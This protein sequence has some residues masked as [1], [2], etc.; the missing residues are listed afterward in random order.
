M[1]KPLRALLL[2]AGFG[3][4]LKP[5][6]DRTPKCLVEINGVPIIE[7]WLNHLEEI[8]C[9]AVLVNT[10]Y[11][12]KKVEDYLKKR[13]PRKMLIKEVYEEELLGTAGTLIKN[14]DFFE[15]K[16]I[17]MIHCDN[18]T[19]FNLKEFLIADKNKPK[20]CL[21][22]M[23]TFNTDNPKNCGVVLT[24][25][26][27]RITNFFEKVDNPPTKIA[28]AAI[29]LFDDIFIENLPQK[30]TNL[31]DFSKDIIPLFI[32]KIYT[33]HTNNYFID[34][35]TKEN[36]IKAKTIFKYFKRSVLDY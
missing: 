31:Y 20:D 6:T 17:I 27:K 34:I 36:L 24:D 12:H 22:T 23:L 13:K 29:Y 9:E 25:T 15:N 16:K 7:Y 35:G 11:L 19:D 1:N 8:N 14:K 18:M 32:D 21:M 28:N 30:Q 5:I 33:Y 2:S 4:R 26:E 10:H 3:K